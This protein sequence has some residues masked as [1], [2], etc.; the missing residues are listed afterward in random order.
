MEV[1]SSLTSN[2]I[3]LLG[4]YCKNV[5]CVEISGSSQLT[6]ISG[7]FPL[8]KH[9]RILRAQGTSI[10]GSS[11]VTLFGA[12]ASAVENTTSSLSA[13]NWNRLEVLDLSSCA[14]LTDAALVSLCVAGASL[15]L[16]DLSMN[17]QLTD[18]GVAFLVRHLSQLQELGLS[19]CT[20]VGTHTVLAL[21]S[22]ANLGS[23]LHTLKISHNS[24]MGPPHV[25]DLLL[26]LKALTLLDITYVL[27][28]SPS[29][30]QLQL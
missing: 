14:A 3:D 10:S 21:K 15:K 13:H 26:F 6:D 29:N 16:L 2:S 7:L 11:V 27:H 22:N 20:R 4:I 23:S 9:L 18:S 28:L 12:P 24:N 1:C 8:S 30:I 25:I 5:K 19:G 17:H